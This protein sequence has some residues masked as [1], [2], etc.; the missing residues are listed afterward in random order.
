MAH[1][2]NPKIKLINFEFLY[3]SI[4]VIKTSIK[5]AIKYP[6]PTVGIARIIP[7]HNPK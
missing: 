7:P 4:V 6:I 5:I 2:D 3:F 1:S